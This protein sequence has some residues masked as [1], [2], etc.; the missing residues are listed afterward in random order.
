MKPQKVVLL[1]GARRV[2]KTN[3]MQQ[4]Q[5]EASEAFLFLNGDDF[6]THDLLAERTAANYRRLLGEK[7]LLFVDEAQEIPDI[8]KKLKLMVDTIEGIRILASGSSAF[9]LNNQMAEPLTGRMHTFYLHPIAQLELNPLQDY[10]QIRAELEERL[11]LGSYPELFHLKD[12]QEKIQYLRELVNAYLLK[13]ILVFEGIRKRETILNLLKKMAFRTGSEISLEALGKEL[14]ISKNTVE[15]YLDLF[16]KVFVMYDL[17]GFTRNLDNEISKKRK[18]FFWDNGI[19][20]ALIGNFNP[21]SQREDAGQL[22]ENY[23][24]SERL[25][26]NTS[27]GN[28]AES[29]FWRTHSQQEVDLI[30]TKADLIEAFEFKFK[31]SEARIPSL[32]RMAYPEAAFRTIHPANYLEFI[33]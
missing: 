14:Q 10:T 20:N 17:P 5:S 27:Q 31:T 32:F 6:H 26:K 25:K 15:K 22:W 13:D 23:L 2:G 30:E 7:R 9:E 21:L 1:L 29:F 18:W 8:G 3:L 12:W 28:L 24:Q 33:S 4:I 16:R 19:R 11:I